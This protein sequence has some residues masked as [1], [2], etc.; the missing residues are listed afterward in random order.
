MEAI[1]AVADEIQSMKPKI[2]LAFK[3]LNST[4]DAMGRCTKKLFYFLI[5][6]IFVIVYFMKLHTQKE[7]LRDP[8]NPF[9]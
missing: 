5:F 2:S 9:R 6:M 8:D 4:L 1:S 3:E 7:L